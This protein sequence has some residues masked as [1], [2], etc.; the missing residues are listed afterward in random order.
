VARIFIPVG[1]VIGVVAAVA[2]A[3]WTTV[4]MVFLIVGQVMNLR[5][6]QRKLDGRPPSR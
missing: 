6:S 5:G 2:G 4:A 1:I 3:W